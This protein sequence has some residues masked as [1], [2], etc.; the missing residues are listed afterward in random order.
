MCSCTIS[1]VNNVCA[2][3]PHRRG[4]VNGDT[5]ALNTAPAALLQMLVQ[6]L[7]ADAGEHR[8]DSER[9]AAREVE[10]AR[11]GASLGEDEDAR[12]EPLA[13][14]AAAACTWSRLS[15]G[16]HSGP[17]L[18]P[19][20]EAKQPHAASDAVDDYITLRCNTGGQVSAKFQKC[21]API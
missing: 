16:G 20:H 17:G 15:W 2:A 7:L 4:S 12:R 14:G 10:D 3:F 6:H 5:A 13:Q 1:A 9:R 8:E 11:G 21:R 19:A 18:G